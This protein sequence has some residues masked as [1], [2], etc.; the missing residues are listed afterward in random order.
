M[1]VP[2]INMNNQPCMYT[3]GN[4]YKE[5]CKTILVAIYTVM[6]DCQGQS[7]LFMWWF[8]LTIFVW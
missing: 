2:K 5:K 6:M 1:R 8:S 3:T 4:I 7:I